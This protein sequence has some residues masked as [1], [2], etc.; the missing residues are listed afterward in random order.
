MHFRQR[1]RLRLKNLPR[2]RPG[3]IGANKVGNNARRSGKLPAL[4]M[5]DLL[6]FAETGYSSLNADPVF[7]DKALAIFDMVDELELQIVRTLVEAVTGI[8]QEN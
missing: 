5:P 2:R 7:Q 6:G 4:K 8:L 3:W 1:T